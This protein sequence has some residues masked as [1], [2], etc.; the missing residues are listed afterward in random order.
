MA[1]Q[2][3]RGVYSD[4]TPTKMVP[5]EFAV[6]NSGDPNST[7][8]K[9]VYI[10]FA[11][12]QAK[13]LVMEEDVQNEVA[14]AT[15][16]IAQELTQEVE[17]AIA[18]DVQAAQTAATNASTSAQTATTKASEAAASATQ[19][20]QTVANIIDNTLTQTGK[21]ADAKV[22]GD[23]LDGLKEDLSDIHDDVDSI[24]NLQN[25]IDEVI[26]SNSYTDET[27]INN[28]PTFT[29]GAMAQT[30]VLYPSYTTFN[31]TQ[32]IAVQQGDVVTAIGNS[33]NA[34]MRWVCAYSGDTV[35]SAKG[36]AADFK[37]YTVP[38]GIDGVVITVRINNAVNNI[39]IT[40]NEE[41]TAVYLKHLPM[42]YMM[43]KG[44]MNDG[45]SLA[46]PYHNVKNDNCYIFNANITT[47]DSIVFSKEASITVDS[48]NIIVTND[49]TSITIPHG[50]TIGN[51]ITILVEN[52]ESTNT[53]LIRVASDGQTFDYTAPVRF[54]MDNGTPTITSSGTTLTDCTFSWVSKKVNAPIWIFGDSYLSWYQQRWTYYLAEDGY[55]KSVML[56]G[57]AGQ[58]SD[59]A[60]TALV[61]LLSV[62][63][64]KMVVWCLGMN[65]AD[66][67]EAVNASWYS[68]F[69]KIVQLREKYGF[70]LILYTVPTTPIMEND[71][72]NA[73][74]RESGYRY[75][76]ADK[77]VRI[78]ADGHWVTG[79]LDVDNVHPTE[80]GAKILYCKILADLPEIMCNM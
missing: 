31:Y 32:K 64:P 62:T 46:L 24:L 25:T 61:N 28:T 4:F 74:I 38:D 58:A 36:N 41:K 70:E 63:T 75:I 8:G 40:R 50:L 22:T 14:K 12:G 37:T 56:N 71:Y 1:I 65:N 9:G 78:D 55:T 44:A 26:E 47:F 52:E 79:A 53:S 34:S 69:L 23:E 15:E 18:D 59:T 60:Y 30:G 20:A 35:V 17:A 66:T 6:V 80:I 7:S 16:D 45:E 10:S 43:D 72:K 27:I 57:Y 68:Y 11:D 13:R 42:G 3:R 77:A 76:E 2:N 54:V 21:A 67:S 29:V 51:N 49:M 48:T 39:K 73:I 33:D 19:A 5:G